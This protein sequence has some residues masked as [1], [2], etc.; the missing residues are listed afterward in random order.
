M[1][2]EN[3]HGKMALGMMEC[4]RFS[5]VDSNIQR[6]PYTIKLIAA[7]QLQIYYTCS[8]HVWRIA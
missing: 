5:F 8:V 7:G 6:V 1:K 3:T 4:K 2:I